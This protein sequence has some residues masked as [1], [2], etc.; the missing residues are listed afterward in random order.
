MVARAHQLST[1]QVKT[2]GPEAHER[3]FEWQTCLFTPI[4][5]QGKGILG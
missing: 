5:I 2:G 4:P 1:H 3:P